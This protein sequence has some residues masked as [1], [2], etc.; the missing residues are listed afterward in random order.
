[1]RMLAEMRRP[2]P[3]PLVR[4]PCQEWA[5]RLGGIH[6]RLAVIG[7][8][9]GGG[10]RPKRLPAPLCCS[11]GFH[12]RYAARFDPDAA[13]DRHHL[14][15]TRSYGEFESGSLP[16]RWRH[17]RFVAIAASYS[18]GLTSA[19]H[20]SPPPDR[21]RR[22]RARRRGDFWP[23]H[24]VVFSMVGRRRDGVAAESRAPGAGDRQAHHFTDLAHHA[25][26][27]VGSL[28]F[29]VLIVP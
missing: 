14:F 7:I 15:S 21:E 4:R 27:N 8:S 9:G 12:P 20:A 18:L 19:S 13:A 5:G 16:S 29:I 26:S 22:F 11:S 25:C 10:R 17:R 3:T 28:F 23:D 1:M 6:G 2:I 24:S